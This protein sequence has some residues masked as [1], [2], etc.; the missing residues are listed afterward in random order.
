MSISITHCLKDRYTSRLH[1]SFQLQT[2]RSIAT[3]EIDLN[4]IAIQSK[5][6]H[7][8]PS[9]SDKFHMKKAATKSIKQKSRNSEHQSIHSLRQ[10]GIYLG[11]R[12]IVSALISRFIFQTVINRTAHHRSLRYTFANFGM[13][14]NGFKKND[15]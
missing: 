14:Y 5:Y 11:I 8:S 1:A 12:Y 10:D 2:T 9:M 15:L 13:K 6:D 3:Y 7:S 4:S